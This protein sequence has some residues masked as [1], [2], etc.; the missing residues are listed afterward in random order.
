MSIKKTI[1]TVAKTAVAVTLLSTAS[2]FAADSTAIVLDIMPMI[3]DSGW[4][5]VVDGAAP[6]SVTYVERTD[7]KMQVALIRDKMETADDWQTAFATGDVEGYN[8]EKVEA[9][10]V[11]YTVAAATDTVAFFLT[12]G[13]NVEH[14][15][16]GGFRAV[17]EAGAA[18]PGKAVTETI[19]LDDFTMNWA[20]DGQP[21]KGDDKLSTHD[22]LLVKYK[23]VA[24]GSERDVSDKT[25][26][27]TLALEISALKLM[28]TDT[29]GI[30]T[31]NISLNRVKS[32]ISAITLSKMDIKVP[33]TDNYK[34][35]IFTANGRKVQSFKRKLNAGTTSIA[36]NGSA[37]T[38]N[39][40]VVRISG[41]DMKVSQKISVN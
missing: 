6:T 24:F 36:W 35:E 10:I 8:F 32:G 14:D 21:F 40:Y 13:V 18:T 16:Y 38:P 4:S 1:L 9:V 29:T 37:L 25:P 5:D 41:R 23:G 27:D 39:I 31:K 7:S 34:I 26:G 17:L 11:T 15:T 30:I 33:T 20:D 28:V 22:S 3:G 19:S 12:D 2:I